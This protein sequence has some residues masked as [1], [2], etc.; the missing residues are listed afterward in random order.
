[1][2]S[3][4]PEALLVSTVGAGTGVTLGGS[5]DAPGDGTGMGGICPGAGGC[6]VK[7]G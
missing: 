6:D 7:A 5:T 3:G 4:L 1:M 2:S